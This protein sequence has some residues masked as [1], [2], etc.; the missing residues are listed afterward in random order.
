MLA[1]AGPPRGENQRLLLDPDGL[2]KCLLIGDGS[3]RPTVKTTLW[4]RSGPKTRSR[5]TFAARQMSSH[6]RNSGM[7]AKSIVWVFCWVLWTGRLPEKT[8][9]L[10][11]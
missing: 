7:P 3:D 10:R 5:Q 4:T 8:H 9:W 6:S 11:G 1:A 2:R